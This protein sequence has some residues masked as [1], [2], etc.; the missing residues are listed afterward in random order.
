[1]VRSELFVDDCRLMD[2]ECR[3]WLSK[4]VIE[5]PL[6]AGGRVRQAISQIRGRIHP[7]FLHHLEDLALRSGI[8]V[9]F[10]VTTSHTTGY[11]HPGNLTAQPTAVLLNSFTSPYTGSTSPSR[12]QAPRIATTSRTCVC[13]CTTCDK[14][15]LSPS[16]DKPPPNRPPIRLP[17]VNNNRPRREPEIP[18]HAKR[19]MALK[20]HSHGLMR[21]R[22]L[23]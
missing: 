4:N 19:K 2:G 16:D 22:H 12:P 17:A 15:H 9:T 3:P 8:E 21:G 18:V 6:R 1:M 11:L 23:I 10:A 13:T 7:A 14:T 20:P 5:L